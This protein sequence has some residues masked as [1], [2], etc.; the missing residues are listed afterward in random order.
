MAGLSF[1]SRSSSSAFLSAGIFSADSI[2]DLVFSMC[3]LVMSEWQPLCV[4][5][6]SSLD[7]GSSDPSYSDNLVRLRTRSS[8]KQNLRSGLLF[9][10]GE[11][12]GHDL[13]FA[14]AVLRLNEDRELSVSSFP[15]EY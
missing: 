1:D 11:A 7:R 10:P 12:L 8:Q 3:S 2:A 14:P 5:A 9:V 6:L 13:H 15:L 4:P